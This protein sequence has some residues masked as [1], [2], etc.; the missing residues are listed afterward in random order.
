MVVKPFPPENST[1]VAA[2]ASKILH[3][4]RQLELDRAV[5][6]GLA[7]KAWAVAAAPLTALLIVA[8]FSPALQGYYYTFANLLSL[9]IFAELGLGMVI[10]QF[11]SHEWSQLRLDE[12]GGVTGDPRALS[13][14]ASLMLF[15]TRWFVTVSVVLVLGLGIG[16]YL[17]FARGPEHGIAWV[18][19]WFALCALSGIN[20]CLIPIWSVLEGC[21]QVSSVYRFRLVQGLV[22]SAAIWTAMLLGAELWTAAISSAAVFVAS[23]G[24]LAVTRRRFLVTLYRAPT[25]GEV[26]GWRKELLPMQWKIALSWMSGYFV[27]SFFTP[28]LFHYEGAALAGQFGMSW[29]MIGLVSTVA[30]SW[31]AP[32]APQFGVLAARREFGELDRSFWRLTRVVLVITGLLTLSGCVGILMLGKIAPGFAGRLLPPV[33]FIL[34]LL[35]QWISTS[36]VTFSMYLRA[37]K[38]EPL[39]YVSIFAAVLI[40]TSTIVLGKFYSVAGMGAGFLAAQ[41]LVVPYVVFTWYRCRALWHGPSSVP[42]RS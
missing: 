37:H 4:S 17:F 28:V 20:M 14:L 7:G 29:T 10:I 24:F 8:K 33:P 35:G 2:L 15:A 9:Q 18:L 6:F 26:V 40:G 13:R 3:V 1:I 39:L 41:M 32:K 23:I 5:C 36:S 21:N 38:V 42:A 30:G 16:G 22:V 11:A 19:P 31:V 27:S 34:F 12:R 25:T